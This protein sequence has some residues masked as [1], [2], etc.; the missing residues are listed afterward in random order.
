MLVQVQK[1]TN[2]V[3]AKAAPTLKPVQVAFI[4]TSSMFLFNPRMNYCYA[5]C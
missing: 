5:V 2:D 4:E 3:A 1:V